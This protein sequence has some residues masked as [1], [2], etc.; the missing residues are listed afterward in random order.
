MTVQ[1][2]IL[3][4]PARDFVSAVAAKTPT[5][6]G[7]SVAGLVGSLGV[8]LGEMALQFTRGKKKYAEHEP[9]HARL[10]QRFEHAR[11]MFQDLIADDIAAFQFYQEASGQ[12]DGPAKTEAVQLATAAAIAVPRE[13]TKLAL[14]IMEDLL[15]L[16]T[17]S[18][19]YL[20]TDLMAGAVLS[21]AAIRLSDY[22]VRIN[23]PQLADRQ[24]AQ[25]IRQSSTNDLARAQALLEAIEKVGGGFLP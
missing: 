25:E 9:L 21:A 19:P 18:N 13:M 23:V 3:T 8:A 10:T 17:R 15:E 24:A 2:D 4:L 1:D 22:N 6:G 20:I 11:R 14:A 7:G 16:S 12:P 5:P